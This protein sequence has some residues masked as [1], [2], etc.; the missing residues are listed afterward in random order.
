MS[1]LFQ[2]DNIT[3]LKQCYHGKTMQQQHMV[4]STL[5]D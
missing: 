3:L 2:L 5:K 4:S 1:V